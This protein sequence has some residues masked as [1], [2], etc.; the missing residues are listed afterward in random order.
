MA[1]IGRTADGKS[2]G[3]IGEAVAKALDEGYSIGK[4]GFHGYYFKILQGQGP[5]AHFRAGWITSSRAS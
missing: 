1:C 5:A 2:G 4:P 3:P